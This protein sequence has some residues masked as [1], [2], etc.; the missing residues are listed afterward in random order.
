[1]L[2]VQG[3]TDSHSVL[4]KNAAFGMPSACMGAVT[5]STAHVTGSS[6]SSTTWTMTACAKCVEVCDHAGMHKVRHCECSA[7][8][9]DVT[10][11]PCRQDQFTFAESAQ[12]V[13]CNWN[14]YSAT[15]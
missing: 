12:I 5:G 11:T 13:Q 8:H 15:M 1:M 3:N 6:T 4:P 7:C 14:R 2:Q 10:Y 9:T